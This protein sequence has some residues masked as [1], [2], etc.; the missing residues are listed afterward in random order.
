M[1]KIDIIVLH[2]GDLLVTLRC[3]KNVEKYKNEYR[4]LILIN[5]DPVIDLSNF[6]SPRKKRKIINTNKNLG[7]AGGVNIG[8][9][10]AFN[11]SASYVMLLNNDA[12]IS[13][14]TISILSDFLETTKS[15]GIVGPIIKFKMGDKIQYD[16]GGRISF[17]EG[18]TTHK[19]VDRINIITPKHVD[20]V[21][22]CCMMIK[23]E[24][25]DAIGYFDSKFF[26]Y[27]EDADYCIRAKSFGYSIWIN[28]NTIVMHELSKTIGRDSRTAIFNLIKSGLIFGK[29]YAKSNV[30]NKVF[31]I[32]QSGKFLIHNPL[33]LLT[34]IK[35]WK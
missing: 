13:K 5:N 29:K 25:V 32:R 8:I 19:N 4:E 23:K 21:S 22:G 10:Y 15:S 26:L 14:T 27:Y 20:Y 33:Y 18:K 3:I 2:Y 17:Q 6:I 31:T 34:I 11:N 9:K 7:F 16:L 28:P 24:V 35:A 30:L 12:E 1:K